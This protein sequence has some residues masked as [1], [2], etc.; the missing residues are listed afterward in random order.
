MVLEGTRI[1]QPA[2]PKRLFAAAMGAQHR[3][4]PHKPARDTSYR[5]GE[6]LLS[7]LA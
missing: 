6:A 4:L 1:C 2:P 7:P 5:T 3:R